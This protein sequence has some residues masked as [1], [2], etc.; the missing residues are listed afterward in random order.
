MILQVDYDLNKLKDYPA[1]YSVLKTAPGWLRAM[2]SLWFLFVRSPGTVG[3]W[4]RKIQ[5]VM[6]AD[7]QFCIHNI[8]LPV[9]TGEYG[10][11]LDKASWDWLNN[12]KNLS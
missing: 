10:G 7:D 1:L 8:T 4:Q 9:R 6:D 5:S 3:E 12:H 2:D 11:T